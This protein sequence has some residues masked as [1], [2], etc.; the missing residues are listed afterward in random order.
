MEKGRAR[1]FQ[2][3]TSAFEQ[4]W[5]VVE[6]TPRKQMRQKISDLLCKCNDSSVTTSA[7][8]QE[9]LQ[10][11]ATFGSPFATQ[12]VRS[13]HRDDAAERQSIIWLLTV[14][15]APETIPLLQQMAVNKRLPRA[16]RLSAS[17]ALAGMG[18]T[19]QNIE[20]NRRVHLY[21]LS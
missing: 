2:P 13:L 10:G 15:N 14:L 8:R 17:L 12:L 3:T 6:L 1:Q 19:A 11:L 9:L 20:K 21:A 18:V 16:V 5:N 4:S 7:M